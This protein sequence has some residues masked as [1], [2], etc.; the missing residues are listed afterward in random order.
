M[1]RE[2]LQT[3]ATAALA[4]YGYQPAEGWPEL[5][6]SYQRSLESLGLVLLPQQPDAFAHLRAFEDGMHRLLAARQQQPDGVLALALDISST[7]Q[8]GAASYR[9][10]L[11]KYQSSV[12]F[13]DA[14][15][16]LLLAG[17]GQPVWLPP[18]EV[19]PFLRQLDRWLAGRWASGPV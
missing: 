2:E 6:A 15:I 3:A 11:N 18:A 5:D 10:A 7:L 8:P 13:E 9:R 14:G 12:V 4:A 1:T 17:A 16:G 19:N